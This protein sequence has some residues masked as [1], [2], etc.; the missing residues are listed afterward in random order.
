M[1]L[2]S[3]LL[4][5]EPQPRSASPTLWDVASPCESVGSSPPYGAESGVS[6]PRPA[7]RPHRRGGGPPPHAQTVKG[8]AHVAPCWHDGTERPSH[9]PKAPEDQQEYYSGKK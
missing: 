7:A 5:P 6:R 2:Y 1:I 4:A 8:W 3:D 9:R